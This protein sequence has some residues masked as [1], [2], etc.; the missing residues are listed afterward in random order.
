MLAF[1]L[2]LVGSLFR[3]ED[4]RHLEAHH[5]SSFTVENI[6]R[7]HISSSM[8]QNKGSLFETVMAQILVEIGAGLG[9]SPEA[10]SG[11]VG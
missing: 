11:R 9:K 2:V 8:F 6:P 4:V 10:E 5:R 1:K 7:V 3:L